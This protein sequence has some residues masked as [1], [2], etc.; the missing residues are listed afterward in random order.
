MA[1]AIDRTVSFI[2][3]DGGVIDDSSV[4]SGRLTCEVDFGLCKV[5]LLA[6]ESVETMRVLEQL[7]EPRMRG[8]RVDW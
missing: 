2:M 1:A 6:C 7:M 8:G 3:T 5:D 4:L